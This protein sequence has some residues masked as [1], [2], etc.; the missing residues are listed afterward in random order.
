MQVLLVMM[1]ASMTAQLAMRVLLDWSSVSLVEAAEALAWRSAILVALSIFCDVSV[2]K[3][4]KL[5]RC[6]YSWW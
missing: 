6:E 5:T 2:L 1:A 3:V 4:Y